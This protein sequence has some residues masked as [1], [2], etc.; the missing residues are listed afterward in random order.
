MGPLELQLC[1]DLAIDMVR[2]HA[3]E[4]AFIDRQNPDQ[5]AYLRAL[6]TETYL[7]WATTPRPDLGNRTPI[8]AIQD[9]RRSSGQPLTT[10]GS[11]PIRRVELYTDL[12]QAEDETDCIELEG[13]EIT[14]ST[15]ADPTSRRFGNLKLDERTETDSP[16]LPDEERA[17]FRPVDDARWWAFVHRYLR[18]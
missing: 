9:E 11:T 2:I 17:V 12:P 6:F 10:H 18:D 13:E 14:S 16:P 8:E 3:R 5:V 1:R 7:T 15:P 4:V